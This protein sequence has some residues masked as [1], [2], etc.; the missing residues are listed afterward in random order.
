MELALAALPGVITSCLL[1][2][3]L[4][5]VMK[6]HSD[7]RTA[8]RTEVTAAA[9]AYDE[10]TAGLV[11]SFREEISAL[12]QARIEEVANLLQRIQAPEAAVAQH[13]GRNAG[14]D[15]P[16]LDLEDDMAMLEERERMLD[17]FRSEL[18]GRT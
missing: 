11:S 15:D 12:N 10:R 1:V 2:W 3:V 16:P 4:L 14:P 18:E 9:R 5:Q 17:N 8:H 6:T 7:E 13:A